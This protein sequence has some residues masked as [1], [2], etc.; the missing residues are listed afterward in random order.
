MTFVPLMS[1]L[2]LALPFGPMLAWKRGDLA[3]AAQRLYWAALLAFIAAVVTLVLY[4]RGPWLAPFAIGIGIWVVAGA[5][6]ETAQRVKLG[7]AP[8]EEVRRRARN[9][10]RSAW[11]GMLAHLGM[12]VSVIGIAATSAW[13]SEQVVT[14][15][16]GEST[17]IAGYQVGFIGVAPRP[18]PNYRELVGVFDVQRSGKSVTRLESA[19]RRF[20][21]ERQTVTQAGILNSWRGD[22]YLVL[23][24]ESPGGANVVRAYFNP[25]VRLIWLGAVIMFIGGA[26][27]L[28]DRRLRVG[29][30]RRAKGRAA[31]VPAE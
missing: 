14:L 30:P 29:A 28:S 18:G 3:G 26:L 20:D 17:S 2:L 7:S 22:L 21:V 8:A 23:G 11:G 15:K 5:I 16:P 24:D 19:K 6:S 1:P 27:S 9:L 12:G 10:P 31:A 25:L 4:R 13:Q